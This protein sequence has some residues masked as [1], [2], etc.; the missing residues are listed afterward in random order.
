MRWIFIL[1]FSFMP[2]LGQVIQ[3]TIFRTKLKGVKVQDFLPAPLLRIDS[4]KTLR[5]G[6]WLTLRCYA[7]LL[8]L[9]QT[10]GDILSFK[11]RGIGSSNARSTSGTMFTGFLVSGPNPQGYYTSKIVLR[12]RLGNFA[13][14]IPLI[15]SRLVG[16]GFKSFDNT[17]KALSGFITSGPDANGYVYLI[18]VCDV[19]LSSHESKPPSDK[20]KGEVRPSGRFFFYGVYP[21]PVKGFARIKFGVGK[22]T[23]VEIEVLDVN[24]R[25]I[26]RLLNKVLKPGVYSVGWNL[27]DEKGTKV[28]SGVYFVRYRAGERIFV[29]KFS[30][31]D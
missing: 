22:E 12:D 13:D 15:R 10:S 6:E 20:F 28:G 30:I 14:T 1:I 8:D 25:V 16:A 7:T 24:G 23:N 4:F 2:L 21:N 3:D 11:I 19:A 26:K 5:L 27:L 17:H 29:R 9:T 31:M 18:A